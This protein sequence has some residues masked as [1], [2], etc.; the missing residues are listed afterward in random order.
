MEILLIILIIATIVG[1]IVYFSI[2]KSIEQ[3]TDEKEKAPK[4]TLSSMLNIFAWLELVCGIILAFVYGF[5]EESRYSDDLAFNA[6]M[7][8]GVLFAGIIS[9]MIFKALAVCVK[10]ANKYLNS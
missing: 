2:S 9:F 6:A 8:F 7:F 5:V 3:V 4:S 10:A 1:L